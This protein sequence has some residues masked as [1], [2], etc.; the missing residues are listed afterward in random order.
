MSYP[1][2]LSFCFLIPVYRHAHSLID[3][4]HN[5][6]PYQIPCIVVDDGNNPPLADILSEKLTNHSWVEVLRMPINEGKGRAC[7]AGFIRAGARNFT[8]ALLLDADGQHD[9]RDV[10]RFL[11]LSR[12]YPKAVILGRPVFDRSAPWSRRF[13]RWMSQL[14]VWI[15]TL[16]FQIGDPLF[17]YRCYPLEPV[18]GLVDSKTLGRR[19]NFDPEIIVRLYWQN[20][21]IMN[22]ESPVR[23]PDGGI[24]NFRLWKD[25]LLLSWLH[26]RLFFGMLLRCPELIGR[27]WKKK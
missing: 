27:H 19:M 23:Y 16:S 9:E 7:R 10:P 12:K 26:T 17:G 20:V 24:S 6:E 14:W 18:L 13:G 3:V 22:L 5:L 8:H 2:E 15:E 1:S 11:D 25:N 4:L 21:P